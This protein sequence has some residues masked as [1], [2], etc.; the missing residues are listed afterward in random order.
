MF[1]S[2]FRGSRPMTRQIHAN[3]LRID[4]EIRENHSP[5]CESDYNISFFSFCVNI[6]YFAIETN[7][8]M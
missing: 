2:H 7:T 6:F 1:Q 3:W 8:K 5:R 4:L